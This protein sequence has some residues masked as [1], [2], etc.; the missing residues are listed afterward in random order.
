MFTGIVESIGTLRSLS[1]NGKGAILEIEARDFDFSDVALGDSIACN[2][3]CLTVTRLVPNGF[4]ADVSHETI[5]CTNFKYLKSGTKLNLEKALTP[6]THMGGHMVLGH[7][8]GIGKIKSIAKKD[9]VMDVWIEAPI[10]I[11]KY[12]AFKGS[13]TVDGISL[14][15]NEVVDNSFRLTLIPHTHA[16][17]IA[18]MWKVDDIVNLEVDVLARY[19]ERLLTFNETDAKGKDNEILLFKKGSIGEKSAK[20]VLNK[21]SL[22]ADILRE[23]GFM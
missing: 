13:I 8:D 15:V 20:K 22:S 3:V 12:I 17:T 5:S 11:C 14:T 23:N 18:D 7:V 21:S 19:L 1:T 16:Q 2:G 6:T 4:K 9:D 10:D